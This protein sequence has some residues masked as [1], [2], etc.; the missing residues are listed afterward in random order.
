MSPETRWWA[1]T[2]LTISLLVAGCTSF[3]DLDP[4]GAVAGQLNPGDEV[5]VVTVDGRNYRFTVKAVDA[6]AISGDGVRV[7]VAD[8][9]TLKRREI[10]AGKTAGV[11][12]GGYVLVI[13]IPVMLGMAAFLIG[14]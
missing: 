10:S 11:A 1:A 2:A 13:G 7:P 8:I 6:E 14:L 5:E 4:P 9:A 3:D 12:A